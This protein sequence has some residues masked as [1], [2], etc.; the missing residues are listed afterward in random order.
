[1]RI[2]DIIICKMFKIEDFKI[3]QTLLEEN[4]PKT[5]FLR[6]NGDFWRKKLVKRS[7]SLDGE[8][9]RLLANVLVKEQGLDYDEIPKL[10]GTKYERPVLC[11]IKKLHDLGI[12]HGDLHI[13]NIVLDDSDNVKFV[14][15]QSTILIK[16]IIKGDVLDEIC[17]YLTIEDYGYNRTKGH[18]LLRELSMPF[19]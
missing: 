5:Y 14:N 3:N 17:D 11:A 4:F 13:Y 7:L 18:I 2:Q 12:F 8:T 6:R 15:F 10:S 16:D 1:M 9:H 19:V